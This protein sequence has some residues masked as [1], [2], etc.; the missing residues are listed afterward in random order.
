MFHEVAEMKGSA[1][2]DA[3][4]WQTPLLSALPET[5]TSL[6]SFNKQDKGN[7]LTLSGQL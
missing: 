1:S 4:S 5:F 7:G 2:K 6:P 3:T